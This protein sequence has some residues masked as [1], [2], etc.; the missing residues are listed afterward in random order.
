MV[1]RP[2]LVLSEGRE[3]KEIDWTRS[4]LTAIIIGLGRY[5]PPQ[6]LPLRNPSKKKASSPGSPYG[7][8]GALP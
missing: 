6:P 4:S 8:F 1:T 2:H 3:E 7:W 5:L